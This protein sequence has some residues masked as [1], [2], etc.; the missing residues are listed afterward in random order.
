LYLQANNKFR[1]FFFFKPGQDRIDT[2]AAEPPVA[3]VEPVVPLISKLDE[4]FIISSFCGVYPS[5]AL[6]AGQGDN[7]FRLA[8]RKAF[9]G[10]QPRQGRR[11]IKAAA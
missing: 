10:E 1:L 4:K 2:A 5:D 9:L 8:G 7:Q 6:L 11:G 3:T